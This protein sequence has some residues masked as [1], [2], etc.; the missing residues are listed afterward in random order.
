MQPV[1]QQILAEAVVETIEIL[2]RQIQTKALE[3]LVL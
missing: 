3:D 2:V 1:V